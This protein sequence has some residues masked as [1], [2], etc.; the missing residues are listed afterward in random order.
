M[1][2]TT[3]L[4]GYFLLLA[5]VWAVDADLS[6]KL[7]RFDKNGDGWFSDAE[8][9]PAAERAM[10]ELTDDTGRA[11][12]PVIGLPYT[13]IWVFVCFSIL[14][15]AEWI[16]KMFGQKSNDDEMTPPVVRYPES[17]VNPYQPPGVG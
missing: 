11:L 7:D 15:L 2:F 16:T 12:A 5:A 14:Y 1:F 4:A 3:V 6:S 17:D 9:T 8:M 13:A 10:Q